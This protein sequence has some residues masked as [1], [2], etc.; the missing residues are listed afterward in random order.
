MVA[1]AS[2]HVIARWGCVTHTAIP[3]RDLSEAESV[4]LSH[5]S[6]N[7]G[8]SRRSKTLRDSGFAPAWR[9][10]RHRNDEISC[11][12]P[13]RSP[14]AQHR[15]WRRPDHR[16]APCPPAHRRLPVSA[17]TRRTPAAT[18]LSPTKVTSRSRR[19][20]HMRAAA[21]LDRIGLCRSACPWR[22]REPRHHTSR[23]TARI[24]PESHRF[25]R[26]ISRVTTGAFLQHD[27]IGDLL[28]SRPTRRSSIG[29]GWLKSKRR[30]SGATSEPFWAT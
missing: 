5:S 24:A 15:P 22:R 8:E 10:S 1:G 16:P 30:R 4:N 25:V 3:G 17:S 12:S 26:S 19:C 21:K 23:R 20:G 18:A 2:G 13:L 11:R 9:R 27:R 29:F 6:W 7:G 28:D 14:P